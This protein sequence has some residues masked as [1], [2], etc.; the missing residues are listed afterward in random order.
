MLNTVKIDKKD[1]VIIAIEP[2]N[3]TEDIKF[4][5]DGKIIT[6]QAIDNIT[7]YHKIAVEDIKKGS[8]IIK[9]GEHIGQASREIL[10]GEHVHTHNVNSVREEL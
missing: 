8:P 9:Y 1:N 4:L 7:I 5:K 2:I 3:K 6:L 10:K